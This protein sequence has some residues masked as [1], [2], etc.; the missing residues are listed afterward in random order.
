MILP[1]FSNFLFIIINL[2]IYITKTYILNGIMKKKSKIITMEKITMII[3]LG[4]Y[5]KL[6]YIYTI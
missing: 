4:H 6:V 1:Y 5:I 2:S 3:K